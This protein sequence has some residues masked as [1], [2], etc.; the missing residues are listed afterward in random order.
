MSPVKLV[1]LERYWRALH[2]EWRIIFKNFET[3]NIIIFLV[4]AHFAWHFSEE[5]II[6]WGANF[7]GWNFQ[8]TFFSSGA[9]FIESFSTRNASTISKNRKRRRKGLTS[10][11]IFMSLHSIYSW[12]LRMWLNVKYLGLFPFSIDF[13]LFFTIFNFKITGS[14]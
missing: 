4:P 13:L 8:G 11:H 12:H 9:I 10:C 7:M 1:S 5:L 2:F 6:P 3:E 14:Y